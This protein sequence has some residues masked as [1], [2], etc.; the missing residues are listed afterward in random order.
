MWI[1]INIHILYSHQ[2]KLGTTL[3]TVQQATSLDIQVRSHTYVDAFCYT[4]PLPICSP[5][6][7][8]FANCPLAVLKPPALSTR[9]IVATGSASRLSKLQRHERG[10]KEKGRKEDECWVLERDGQHRPKQ[11]H[12]R[13]AHHTWSCCMLTAHSSAGNYSKAKVVN[14]AGESELA[15]QTHTCSIHV[16]LASLPCTSDNILWYN[17][18]AV[19]W[20][21]WR[22]TLVSINSITA[23]L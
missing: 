23:S 20:S 3:C 7:A 1:H 6:T 16:P 19:W 22:D 17:F 18:N 15:L 9:S 11:D 4:F 12:L 5:T 8:C 14:N 2:Y 21:Q 10:R 13:L